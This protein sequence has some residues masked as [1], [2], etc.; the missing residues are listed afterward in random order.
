MEDFETTALVT[1]D[2][3]PTIWKRYIDDTIVIWPHGR[4]RLDAFL[5]HINMLH[6]NITFT[7]E[8]EEDH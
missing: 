7:V 8:V 6:N 1:A 3:Q 2:Y 5:H 4:E